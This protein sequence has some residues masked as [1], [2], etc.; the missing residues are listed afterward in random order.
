MV[1]RWDMLPREFVE[2]LEETPNLPA[3]RCPPPARVAPALSR[4]AEDNLQR[5]PTTSAAL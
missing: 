4:A 5:S 1:K 2:A 3:H